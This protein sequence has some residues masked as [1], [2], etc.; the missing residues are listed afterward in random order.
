MTTSNE[1]LQR[2]L[3]GLNP[4]PL[5]E[6]PVSAAT[7]REQVTGAI[8]AGG[9]SSRMGRNKALLDVAGLPLIERTYRTMAELFAEVIV[10]TNTPRDYVF[11]PCPLVGDVYPNVG[12]I[13]GVH[14]ALQHSTNETIFVVPCDMPFLEPR[15]I[16]QLCAQN[17]DW[18]ALVPVSARGVEPLHALY[19]RRCLPQLETRLL[20]GRKQLLGFLR[21]VETRYVDVDASLSASAEP[22]FCNLNTPQ[23]YAAHVPAGLVMS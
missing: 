9:R 15:L 10:V 12:S 5:R 1:K 18:D 17:G 6:V 20:S 11:L 7:I 16:R 22:L 4:V 19:R 2:Q 13:A 23:D 14:S 3:D 8:L 21:S